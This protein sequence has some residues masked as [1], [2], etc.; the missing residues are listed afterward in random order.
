M[1]NTLLPTRIW[2]IFL[3]WEII[4]FPLLIRFVPLPQAS[5]HNPKQTWCLVYVHRFWLRCACKNH[6][7]LQHTHPEPHT[8]TYTQPWLTK[9]LPLCD[10]L[11]HDPRGWGKK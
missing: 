1:C 9:H 3:F 2:C 10:I 7:V 4:L 11:L 5:K 8:H 6:G